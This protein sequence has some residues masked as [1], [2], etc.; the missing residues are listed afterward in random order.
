MLGV[1]V[2]FEVRIDLA[3]D[4]EHAGTAFGDPGLDRREIG[5]RLDL[6]C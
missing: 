4:P 2:G 3:V 6:R 1:P 5:Q